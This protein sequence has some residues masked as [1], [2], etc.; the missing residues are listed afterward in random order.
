MGK[1]R[2]NRARR[3]MP[4]G[5]G[6]TR[7]ISGIADIEAAGE[8]FVAEMPC[9]I[10]DLTDPVL[11][12]MRQ[13]VLGP[14]GSLV[15]DDS[16]TAEPL[17]VVLFEPARALMMLNEQSGLVQEAR[18]EGVIAAG[19]HRVPG[20]GVWVMKPAPG[21]EVRR[22]P[23]G[24]VL[25]DS[26][27]DI[28]AASQVTL[29][30]AWVSAAA[31]HQHVGVFFGPQLGV[32]IPPGMPPAAYTTAKRAAEFRRAREQGLVTA[33][34]VSWRGE[35]AEETLDWVIFMPGSFG[36][37]FAGVYAPIAEFARH[38]GPEMFGLA[39]LRDQDMSVPAE[40]SRTLAV[41]VSRTDIDI[42]DPTENPVNGQVGGVHYSEGIQ[43][44]WRRAALSQG[45]VLLLTG[46]RLPSGPGADTRQ[47]L[48][49]LGDLWA[50]MIPVH[51]S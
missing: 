17:P 15:V 50:A 22:V 35:P 18:I 46:S 6:H 38:G 45:M 27:G 25:R 9:R 32:R 11:G 10:T 49:D 40:P 36:Q 29:E 1:A 48:E 5:P 41:R 21:W 19:F 16:G 8:E 2:R 51:A 14:G 12:G 23:D 39:R 3:Q 33:A 4:R 31:S 47:A 28:W 44:A 13:A 30:P 42:V 26:T 20:A 43:A 37:P 34:T 24:L 7:L